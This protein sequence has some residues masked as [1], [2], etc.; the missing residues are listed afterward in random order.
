MSSTYIFLALVTSGIVTFAIRLFPFLVLRNETEFIE[1]HAVYFCG[2]STS[3][4]YNS[5]CLLSK[6]Y[7]VCKS[8]IWNSR[9]HCSCNRSVVAMVE[10]EYTAQHLCSNGHLYGLITSDVKLTYMLI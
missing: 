5:S 3:Y 1:P 8:T 6:G 10:G 9:N 2:P 4:H 7:F